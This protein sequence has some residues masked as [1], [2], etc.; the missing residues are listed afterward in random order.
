MTLTIE[1]EKMM[2]K[3]IGLVVTFPGHVSGFAAKAR[4][5]TWERIPGKSGFKQEHEWC[6][7]G[8]RTVEEAVS[9]LQAKLMSDHGFGLTDVACLP[10]VAN[11]VSK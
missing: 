6:G 4:V 9:R 11:E 7:E 10:L 5:S 8:G 3:Y 1:R 2:G